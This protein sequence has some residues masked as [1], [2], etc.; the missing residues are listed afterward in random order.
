MVQSVKRSSQKESRAREKESK[1]ASNEKIVPFI[2]DIETVVEVLYNVAG[3]TWGVWLLQ[4]K[5]Q[6]NP[7]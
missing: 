1:S 3:T 6:I 5:F 2:L 7:N 4:S